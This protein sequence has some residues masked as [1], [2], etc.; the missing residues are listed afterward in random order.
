[1]D[2][3]N[4]AREKLNKFM[5]PVDEDLNKIASELNLK[6]SVF[7]IYHLW[8]IYSDSFFSTWIV[9]NDHTIE[10]FKSWLKK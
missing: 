3:N 4:L 1:M 7:E 6:I 9:V 5:D 8:E 2:Y 10:K